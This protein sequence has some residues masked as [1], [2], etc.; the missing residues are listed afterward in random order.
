MPVPRPSRCLTRA[1]ITAALGAVLW[2]GL[3]GCAARPVE[4]GLPGPPVAPL[5]AEAYGPTFEAAVAVLRDA[6]F[7]VDRQ[8]YRF[9]R[10]TSTPKGSPTI[11]E[12][13][14]PDNRTTGDAL[15]STLGNLRRTVTLFFEPV[16]ASASAGGDNSVSRDAQRSASSGTS[17][18]LRVEVLLERVEVPHRRLNGVTKG[19]IFADLREVPAELAARGITGTYWQPVGRDQRL[20][21]HLLER[22]LDRAG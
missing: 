7:N 22:I 17:Y 15:R 4:A 2:M 20:E 9:G 14:K 3:A 1:P 8:D 5:A 16:P 19:P 21:H 18:T 10:I 13:W 12:P 6:G 11:L